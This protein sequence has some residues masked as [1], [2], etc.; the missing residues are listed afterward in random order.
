VY[1]AIKRAFDVACAL[2]GLIGFAL[3]LP[4]LALAIRLDSAGAIF[5]SQTRVG[6]GGRIFTVRK[7]R[8]MITGAE[9]N[10]QAVWATP[11]DPRVT[12]VGRIL[13]RLHLDEVPQFLNVLRGEMSVVGPRPERPELVA[14]LE[15]QIPFYRLRHAVKPGIAG[16]AVTQAD[17]VYTVEDA[18]LRVE[19]DLYYIKH[20]S[21]WLDLWILSRTVWHV[22]TFK[23]R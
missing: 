13:R 3:L 2:V 6:Q 17:K 4:F 18:R 15:Q 14:R 8:T 19:Y 22:L 10:G 12:R 20:Q 1:R 7:L 21:I 11:N 5:Y 9:Q 23:G 16:W